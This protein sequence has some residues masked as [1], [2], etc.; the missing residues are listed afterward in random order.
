MNQPHIYSVSSFRLY[1][2]TKK[3]NFFGN[4]LLEFDDTDCYFSYHVNNNTTKFTIESTKLDSIYSSPSTIYSCIFTVIPN[5]FIL[6]VNRCSIIDT[7]VELSIKNNKLVAKT[8]DINISCETLIDAVIY[9]YRDFQ[10]IYSI[11]YLNLVKNYNDKILYMKIYVDD[12]G[13]IKISMYVH[14]LGN[15]NFYLSPILT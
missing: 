6:L 3:T 15:I 11:N 4:C 2:I 7:D 5:D 14:N 12:F 9:K 10:Y 8:K 1:N 13:L